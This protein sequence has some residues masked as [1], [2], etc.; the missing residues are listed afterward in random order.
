MNQ[1]NENDVL[2]NTF[3]VFFFSFWKMY[4]DNTLLNRQYFSS[5]CLK[6]YGEENYKRIQNLSVSENI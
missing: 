2:R 6:Q 4:V 3:K 5:S 1:F